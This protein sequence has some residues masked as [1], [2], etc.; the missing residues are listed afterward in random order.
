LM[1]WLYGKKSQGI[2][3]VVRTQNPDLNDLRSVISNAQSL[4]LLR[5]GYPLEHAF[6]FSVKDESRFRDALVRAKD[7][8]QKAKGTVTTGYSGQS[9]LFST[10]E[11]IVN[12]AVSIL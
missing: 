1:T 4:S 6:E 3:P 9:D 2:E 7:S 5:Q 11:D 10:I 12:T 8:L